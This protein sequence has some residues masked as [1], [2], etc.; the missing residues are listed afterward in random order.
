MHVDDRDPTPLSEDERRVARTTD[1]ILDRF[2]TLLGRRLSFA[3]DRALL[4]ELAAEARPAVFSLHFALSVEV[5][6]DEG[7]IQHHEAL[8]MIHLL[9]R[10]TAVLGLS[11]FSAAQIVD[12]LADAFAAVFRAIPDR[13]RG[14]LA[15][16]LF[17]GFVRGRE[18]AVSDRARARA[19]EALVTLSLVPGCFAWVLAGDLDA[20][21]IEVRGNELA[22]RLFASEARALVIDVSKLLAPDRALA[23]AIAEVVASVRMV[24]CHGLAAGAQPELRD[25]LF[26]LGFVEE[27]LHVSFE[28]AA[29]VALRLASHE[30]RELGGLRRFFSARRG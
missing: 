13:L 10:R 19:G 15:A 30:I 17:E 26:E 4:P 8:A 24:G 12:A 7:S 11:P 3:E 14:L 5:E 1:V 20:E 27:Q 9:G 25:M 2:E 6:S 16:T 23:A 29:R 21:A 22:R 28:S 18:E